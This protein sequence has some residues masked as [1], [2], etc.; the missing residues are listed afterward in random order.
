MVRRLWVMRIT[1]TLS[2][3]RATRQATARAMFDHAVL[4]NTGS[5]TLRDRSTATADVVAAR[6]RDVDLIDAAD[7]LP[8]RVLLV[9]PG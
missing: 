1:A 4:A 9:L 3:H 7:L 2:S 6:N 5:T 8:C